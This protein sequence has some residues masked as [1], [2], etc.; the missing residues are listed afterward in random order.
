VP[1]IQHHTFVQ[2]GGE[3]DTTLFN[4]SAEGVELCVV[5]ATGHERKGYGVLC[6][7]GE[8]VDTGRH[9]DFLCFTLLLLSVKGYPAL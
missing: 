3:Q 2:G 7:L 9:V 4:V 5:H 8:L 1:A 6:V